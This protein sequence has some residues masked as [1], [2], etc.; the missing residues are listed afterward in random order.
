ML[1]FPQIFQSPLI[2]YYRALIFLYPL[3]QPLANLT[4]L[5]LAF[6]YIQQH[7]TTHI[8]LADI[9]DHL[10]LDKPDPLQETIQ[11]R[12]KLLVHFRVYGE[13]GLSL[14]NQQEREVSLG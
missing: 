9:S 7:L 14:S 12:P 1:K 4:Q 8:Q 2:L 6:S 10:L 3:L 11:T 5:L 13:Q